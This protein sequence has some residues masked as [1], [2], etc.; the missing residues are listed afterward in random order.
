MRRVSRAVVFLSVGVGLLLAGGGSWAGDWPGWRGP[1]G[2]GHSDEKDLPLEWDAKTGK[3]VLWKAL[4][5]G[6]AKR[7]EEMCSPG[8]SCPIVW[9]DRV[10]ITTAV[11]PEGLSREDRKTEIAAHHVLCYRA[12]NGKQLWDIVVPPGKC[13][14]NNMYHGYA[15]ST[16]VT[17]GKLVYALFASGVIAALNF[18]GKIV[19]REELPS[20]RDIDGG[21]CA[22]PILYKDT[23]I[24]SGIA[25]PALRALDKK[26]GK[27]RWEQKARSS[28]RMA[29]PVV[30]CLDGKDQLIHFAGGVQGLDPNT[31]ELLWSCRVSSSQASPVY[32]AGIIYV[33][34]GRG[35]QHGYGIVP[36]G[37]GD[38]TKTNVKWQAKINTAGGS[39]AIAAGDYVYR[40]AEP[41]M[42][43]CYKAATGDLVF[44]ERVSGL[45]AGASPV[46]TADGRIYFASSGRTVVIKAG[47]KLEVLATNNLG[48]GNA[49]CA[50]AI[51][52]GRIF[53]KGKSYLWCIGRK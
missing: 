34:A 11:W 5:H 41:G 13:V 24:L 44:Q 18:D 53:I 47:P 33:D 43:R 16:P 3:N 1:T 35:G 32:G 46:A 48:E 37:K 50:V 36:T 51:S 42:I 49:F 23:V 15:I 27:P 4:L 7:N 38:V 52:N 21:I 14:V 28:N 30:L 8:W 39:S 17:D 45:S 31:G 25:N 6:G 29:T 26:T 20:K 9:G 22:S 19:W 12:S 40:Y 2:M 10:F